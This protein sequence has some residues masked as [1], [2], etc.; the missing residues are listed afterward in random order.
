MTSPDSSLVGVFFFSE[1]VTFSINNE[2]AVKK[3]FQTILSD[4]NKNP[5][6]INVV[7][8]SD[9]F[10]L[11]MNKEYLDHNYYTDI[12]TFPMSKDPLSGDLYICIDR[13]KDYV[14]NNNIPFH[15]ELNRVMIHGVLHLV[16]YKDGTDSEKAEIRRTEDHYLD[17]IG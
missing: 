1:E 9:Q 10:L 2:D 15:S 3:C 6:C 8:C 11:Q 7:F 12:L 14:M 17:L 5:G 16:G 4:H 13:V